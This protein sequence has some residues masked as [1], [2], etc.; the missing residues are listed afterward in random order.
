LRFY[1]PQAIALGISVSISRK[2]KYFFLV[3]YDLVKFGP[4]YGDFASSIDDTI[5]SLERLANIDAD[6]YLV[7]HGKEGIL[8]GDPAHIHRYLE[9]IYKRE[10]KLVDFLSSGPKCLED[11]VKYGIIYG[12]H[13]LTNSSWELSV[14]EQAMMQKHLERLIQLGTVRE[15]G[16]YYCLV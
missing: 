1:I 16:S 15:E 13:K 10:E 3:D 6:V 9:V 12:G 8:D 14:S 5:E 11:I 7:S 2:I 4:Y